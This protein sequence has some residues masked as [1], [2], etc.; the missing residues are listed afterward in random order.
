M[1]HRHRSETAAVKC[2][3][4]PNAINSR[5]KGRDGLYP[6]QRKRISDA[7]PLETS[8]GQ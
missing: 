4:N 5:G 2:E 7:L 6:W 3:A 8:G 1:L